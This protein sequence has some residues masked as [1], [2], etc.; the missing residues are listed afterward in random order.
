MAQFCLKTLSRLAS[1]EGQDGNGLQLENV[2]P[3]FSSSCQNRLKLF[4][5]CS[6]CTIHLMLSSLCS[7]SIFCVKEGTLTKF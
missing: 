6:F 7:G 3:T 4:M 2:R 1:R 5:V